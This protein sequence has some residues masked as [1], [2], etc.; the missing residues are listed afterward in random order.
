M[1]NSLISLKLQ[2]A[3][4]ALD[5]Y[6]GKRLNK[7]SYLSIIKYTQGLKPRK[8]KLEAMKEQLEEANK[9]ENITKKKLNKKSLVGLVVKKNEKLIEQNEVHKVISPE[10]VDEAI[11]LYKN[12]LTKDMR[13]AKFEGAMDRVE[14]RT[15]NIH[16]SNLRK[17]IKITD[18]EKRKG[19]SYRYLHASGLWSSL[20]VPDVVYTMLKG[21]KNVN[22][23]HTVMII[24]KAFVNIYHLEQEYDKDGKDNETKD[25]WKLIENCPRW[26]SLNDKKKQ[27]ILKMDL[28]RDEMINV[29]E[30]T[31]NLQ[32]KQIISDQTFKT[33]FL[34]LTLDIFI[35][36]PSGGCET[37]HCKNKMF[38]SFKTKS[39]KSVNNNCLIACLIQATGKKTTRHDLIRKVLEI[40]LNT[41]INPLSKEAEQLAE[42]FK[43]NL[44]ILSSLNGET[45][46]AYDY[47][48][49][50][51][52]LMIDGSEEHY[53][54]ITSDDHTLKRCERCNLKYKSSHV[55]NSSNIS[56]FNKMIM[57]NDV[58]TYRKLGCSKTVKEQRA[59]ETLAFYDF[60][61]R[62][63]NTVSQVYSVGLEV[64]GQYYNFWGSN[65]LNEFLEFVA[66][67][68]KAGK[69]L[70][71][72]SY[73]GSGF[74]MYFI[75]QKL[76]QK[77]ESINHLMSNNRFI[78][79]EQKDGTRYFDLY[80]YTQPFSLSKLFDNCFPKEKENGKGYFPHMFIGSASDLNYVGPKPHVKYFDQKVEDFEEK[81]NTKFR[82]W[83]LNQIGRAHV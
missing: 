24:V 50:I 62:N 83:Y 59:K 67:S 4:S 71:L 79:L 29:I 13:H 53:Y 68:A 44:I 12:G 43:I 82:T 81:Q 11:E 77:E 52:R 58:I 61:T 69:P 8:N 57:K 39:F 31:L 15:K 16:F 17:Q 25:E 55:C 64:E 40:P 30:N 6:D 5:L 21:S 33:E 23:K 60:E 38:G 1:K 9:K 46:V 49:D 56:Y 22:P 34:N 3:K 42:F 65:A 47:G 63:E 48:E 66:A 45:L 18:E 20:E 74:D 35:N 19:M 36:N 14:G 27:I 32:E 10:A 78:T 54:L 51:I 26:I 7:S 41:K 75:F 76:L 80:L 72:I 2:I 70:T 37:A 28:T 73:N